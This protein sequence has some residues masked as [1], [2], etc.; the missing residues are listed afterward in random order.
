M[1][2]AVN[3]INGV[4]SLVPEDY[5]EHP[6]LGATLRQVRNGKNRVRLSETSGDATDEDATDEDATPATDEQD[7]AE[8][9]K[10]D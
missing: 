1:V 8:K 6:I 5:L 4:V 3:D 9:D 7:T 2:Y 10:E